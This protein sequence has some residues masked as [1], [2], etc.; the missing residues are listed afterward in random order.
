MYRTSEKLLTTGRNLLHAV[1][2]ASHC[3]RWNFWQQLK[4]CYGGKDEIAP[5]GYTGLAEWHSGLQGTWVGLIPSGHH[6]LLP[7]IRLYRTIHFTS[8]VK[9]NLT[10]SVWK[11]GGRKSTWRSQWNRLIRREKC[12]NQHTTYKASHVWEGSQWNRGT[13][14]RGHWT[15]SVRSSQY[16]T[17]QFPVIFPK[18]QAQDRKVTHAKAF[19]SFW[20]MCALV[21]FLGKTFSVIWK[22]K[23][24]SDGKEIKW[25]FKPG[26]EIKSLL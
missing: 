12:R 1:W 5:R 15:H 18:P 10:G 4:T 14:R 6:V 2:N 11:A 9:N 24:E 3:D 25:T 19:C 16:P 22:E 17:V 26:Q 23:Q 20:S 8:C 21:I 13:Q 7:S